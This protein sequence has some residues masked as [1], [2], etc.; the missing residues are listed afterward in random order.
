MWYNASPLCYRYVINEGIDSTDTQILTS[1]DPC[2][3]CAQLVVTT[4]FG[5]GE[6][7]FHAIF[8][9]RSE[10]STSFSLSGAKTWG[11]FHLWNFRSEEQKYMGTKVPVT[12]TKDCTDR[13]R[14]RDL[15]GNIFGAVHS[16]L[17]QPK[18]DLL[19]GWLDYLCIYHHSRNASW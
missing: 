17:W 10:S 6:Q 12:V 19:K 15:I 13:V 18:R 1:C 11:T 14:V 8:P 5:P 4:I 9:S 16:L 7:K 2:S 3:P